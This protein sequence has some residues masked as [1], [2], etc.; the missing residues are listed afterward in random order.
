MQNEIYIE[1]IISN[2]KL[3]SKLVEKLFDKNV[4]Y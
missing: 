1:E 2:I 3:R 4:N